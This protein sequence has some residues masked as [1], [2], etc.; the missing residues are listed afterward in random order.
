MRLATHPHHLSAGASI[1]ALV[2]AL[3]VGCGGK[4][5]APKEQPEKPAAEAPKAEEGLQLLA[6]GTPAPDFTAEAHDGTSISMSALQGNPVVVYFYPKD[7]TA[8]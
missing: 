1:G 8:G 7:K 5:E 2:L 4:K 6:V 3:G